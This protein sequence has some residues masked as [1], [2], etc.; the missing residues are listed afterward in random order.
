[1]TFLRSVYRHSGTETL[2]VPFLSRALSHNVRY[3]LVAAK[4]L[5]IKASKATKDLGPRQ[6]TRYKHV[7]GPDLSYIVQGAQPRLMEHV[8]SCL[9]ASGPLWSPPP[10]TRSRLPH[11]HLYSSPEGFLSSP[12]F[13][14]GAL[15]RSQI[16]PV[17]PRNSA[18]VTP[19]STACPSAY[20][21]AAQWLPTPY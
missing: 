16:G 20:P 11:S 8:A 6:V 2:V 10:P 7:K 19:Q 15:I 1:M 17:S 14:W 3:T 4:P 9:L 21:G 12:I 18:V 13:C 5:C